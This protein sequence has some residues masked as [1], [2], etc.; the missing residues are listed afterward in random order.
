MFLTRLLHSQRHDLCLH[1]YGKSRLFPA[2]ATAFQDPELL[3]E[4]KNRLYHQI[5][6]QLSLIYCPNLLMDRQE[7]LHNMG[8]RLLP[9]YPLELL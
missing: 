1:K 8:L 6:P 3:R 7:E 5:A 4:E 2:P 9:G